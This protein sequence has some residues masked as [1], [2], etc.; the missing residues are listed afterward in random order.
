MIELMIVIIVLAIAA[1]VFLPSSGGSRTRAPRI[2]CVNNLKQVGVAYR[3]WELDHNDQ[4]PA[5]VSITSGGTMEA[6]GLPFMT[7]RVM[8]NELSTPKILVCPADKQRSPS[9]DFQKGFN[10]FQISYFVGLDACSTNPFMFLSGDR[11]ITNA[12]GVKHG[13]MNLTTNDPPGWTHE[14]H[15]RQGNVGLADGSVQQM[16]RS[17]LRSALQYTG[18]A[19]NRVAL[20]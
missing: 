19:N 20:P 2:Q 4:Y 15:E 8:S 6:A 10:K 9:A 16:S 7:F 18:D 3:T 11:N 5:Q 12:S 17:A 13:V 14:M 1:L